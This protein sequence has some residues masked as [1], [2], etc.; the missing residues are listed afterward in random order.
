MRATE[1]FT[2]EHCVDLKTV[3]RIERVDSKTAKQGNFIICMNG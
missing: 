3:E 1:N 2:S